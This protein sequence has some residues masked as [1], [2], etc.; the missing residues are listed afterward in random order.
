M[1]MNGAEKDGEHSDKSNH[2]LSSHSNNA[3]DGASSSSS[4]AMQTS[5]AGPTVEIVRQ[6]RFEVAPRYTDLKFIGEGAYGMVVSAFDHTTQQRV[7]I[8]KITPFEHQCFCQRT[9]REIKILARFRHENIINIQEVIRA[10][11]IDQMKDIYIVQCL[12]ECDLYKLLRHQRLTDEHICYF[13]YQ[14]LR[15]LK[16]IHSANVLHRD[17]KPSNLL[18]NTNCDLKICDFGLARIADP[19]TDHSGLLTEYVATRWY[20]APEIMLNARGYYKPI[21]I[22]SVGCILAEMIGGRPLFPGKHYIE[23]INL[24][25]NV[26]GSPD[27]GDLT[28]IINERARNY[29]SLLPVRKRTPWKQLYPTA[30]ELSLNMLD[31]LLTF[32][33]DRRVTVEEALKHPYLAQYYD[34]SDEPIAPHPFTF[35]MELDDLPLPE[36]KQLIFEEIEV[37]PELLKNPHRE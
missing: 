23:Q 21:D 33:P 35:D 2:D 14:I 15:G 27:E 31:F 13:L 28:S 4:S 29:V 36:L 37:I 18:L 19:N 20:R 26:V 32:N 6:Q 25:L 34:P 3:V 17:L 16:Y 12:M 10:Q 1:Q 11:T 30:S 5:A 8:K 22:W 7:A 9:L 24:I